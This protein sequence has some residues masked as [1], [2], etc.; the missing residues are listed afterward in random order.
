MFRTPAR[1]PGVRVSM[2]SLFALAV[3]VTTLIPVSSAASDTETAA[4][5]PLGKPRFAVA[6]GGLRAESTANW[7]RLGQYDFAADG[8]VSERHWHWS[9]RDRVERAYTGIQASGCPSRDCN[10]QTAAGYQSTGATSTLEGEYTVSGDILRISWN[11]NQWWEEW[12]L[13]SKAGGALAEIEFLGSNFGA[14]HGF[15]YGSQAAWNAR[16]PMAE[17]AAADHDSFVH[18]YHLWKTTG[19]NPEPHIDS[20]DGNPFWMRDWTACGSNDLCLGGT[21]TGTQYYFAAAREPAGHRR[22]TLWHWWTSHADNRGE[23]CYTG[24]S[25]VKPAI[26]IVD[27]N[28]EFHGWVGV[29]ASLNQTTDQGALADDIGVYRIVG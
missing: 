12:K 26:Q 10:V 13:T 11:T 14:T 2:S 24:N 1:L 23:Y 5:L 8:T 3:L 15:G 6:V 25:H 29:E 17:I 22:D 16:V 20:G 9:Q 7:V 27:D 4:G 21:T 18:R 28:G 19:D